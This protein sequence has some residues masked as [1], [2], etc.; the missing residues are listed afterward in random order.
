MNVYAYLSLAAAAVNLVSG[1]Y[2]L[3]RGPGLRLNRLLFAVLMALAAWASG[4]FVMRTAQTAEAALRGAGIAGLGWCLV[5]PLYILFVLAYTERDRLLRNPLTWAALFIPGVFFLVAVWTTRL[6]F[7]GFESSYWGYRELGGVLRMPSR[8]YGAVLFL[9]GIILLFDY[10]RKAKTPAGRSNASYLLVASLIPVCTGLVS[11]IILPLSGVQA[12]ELTMFASTAVG[13]VVVYAILSRGLMTTISRT[14]GSSIITKIREAVFIADEEGLIETVNPSAEALTG[15]TALELRGVPL[16]SLFVEKGPEDA[17]PFASP[18]VAGSLLYYEGRPGEPVPVT[19]SV[20][21]VKRRTGST[22]GSVAV[23]HDMRDAL[24]LIEAQREVKKAT[25]EAE[26]ER[27]RSE[28]L[29]R[30]REEMRRLSGFLENVIDNIAEP[31]Y[32]KDGEG[33]YVF[34][35]SRICEYSGLSRDFYIGKKNEDVPTVPPETAAAF[36]RVEEE[37]K[38]TGEAVVADVGR[39]RDAFGVY[40]FFKAVQTPIKNE[41]GEV[42]FIVGIGSDVTEQRRLDRARLD[43][44]RVAAHELRTPLT[45]LKLGFD[46]LARET[47]G[48]LGEEQQRTLDVLSLSIERLSELARNLLDLASIDAGLIKPDLRPVE[49]GPLVGEAVALLSSSVEEKG[50]E[51]EILGDGDLRPAFADP[52]RVSQ[53]L[54]NLISNAIKYT[55]SGG[56]T[57][58]VRDPGGEHLEVCVADTGVGIPAEQQG[59]IFTSFVKVPNAEGVKEGTGLGLPI[60]KAVVE[61]HGGEIWVESGPGKGSKFFFTLR[62]AG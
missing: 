52:S 53:V 36:R 18:G 34:V 56:I 5:G 26:A 54:Y 14:L 55:E 17:R 24:R 47:R 37:V 30:S 3:S 25:A 42:Q 48:A 61:A 35:N 22:V 51:F 46:L 6:V 8:L 11:D 44:I 29:N 39:I 59:F 1:V 23:V 32:I 12:V 58:S 50:L 15:H 20:E 62:A 4:E 31:L 60:S 13:P 40:H 19:M 43:F 38:A 33:R 10:W 21:A 49:L 27:S 45:S 2:V 28:D 7:R 57:V 9:T 41:A 16:E